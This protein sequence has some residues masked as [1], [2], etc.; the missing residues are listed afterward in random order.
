LQVNNTDSGLLAPEILSDLVILAE[1]TVQ[2]FVKQKISQSKTES[3]YTSF[4]RILNVDVTAKIINATE[5]EFDMDL[6]VFITLPRFINLDE[7]KLAEESA[8]Y[9]LAEVE[10]KFI[11]LKGSSSSGIERDPKTP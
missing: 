4:E 6:Q 7:N 10:K 3:D 1:D 5:S 2:R 11:A 8:D 9:A